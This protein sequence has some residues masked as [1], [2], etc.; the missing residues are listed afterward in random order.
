MG[1]QLQDIKLELDS[2]LGKR[3]MLRANGGRRKSIERLGVLTE[4]YPS[5]FVVQIDQE[6]NSVERLSFSYADILTETVEL[7]FLED[8]S[9]EA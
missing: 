7:T 4:T 3:L 9:K 5:I 8:T 2:Q 1:K 6:Y